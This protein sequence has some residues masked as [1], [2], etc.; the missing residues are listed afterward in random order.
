MQ[1]TIERADEE[2][3]RSLIMEP[4]LHQ[5]APFLFESIDRLVTALSKTMAV[6]HISHDRAMPFIARPSATCKASA[7]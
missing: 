5:D 4:P 3:A 7:R 1:G 6:P 2:L